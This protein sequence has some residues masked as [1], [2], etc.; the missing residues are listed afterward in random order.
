MES[1]LIKE[2]KVLTKEEKAVRTE[3]LKQS[4]AAFN[5]SS[6]LCDSCDVWLSP[7][8][9]RFSCMVC[10]DYDVC[11]ECMIK[12]VHP[13]HALARLTDAETLIPSDNGTT[14]K[15]GDVF[16]SKPRFVTTS[17]VVPTNTSNC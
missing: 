8:T 16:E 4:R 17:N 11:L 1:E 5:G 10:V 15:V 2:R 3:M 14:V 13:T 9:G 12:G 7:S 6:F